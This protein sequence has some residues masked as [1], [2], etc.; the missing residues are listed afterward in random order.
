MPKHNSVVDRLM[1]SIRSG[2]SA[3]S[4]P[5]TVKKMLNMSMGDSLGVA[6]DWRHKFQEE[7]VQMIGSVL[8]DEEEKMEEALLEAK[9][10]CETFDVEKASQTL[11]LENAKASLK[12][13]KEALASKKK[14]FVAFDQNIEAKEQACNTTLHDIMLLKSELDG[15]ARAHGKLEE[16]L[17][18]V[19]KTGKDAEKV[20]NDV[21]N[22]LV[23][24]CQALNCEPSMVS[25]LPI[26]FEKV[27]EERCDFDHVVVE[28]VEGFLVMKEAAQRDIIARSQAEVSTTEAKLDV[29]REELQQSI[30]GKQLLESDVKSGEVDSKQAADNVRATTKALRELDLKRKSADAAMESAKVRLDQFREGALAAYKLLMNH[31]CPPAVQPSA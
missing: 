2:I 3:S 21:V 8:V 23:A 29:A 10:V 16:A 13:K 25:S 15:A 22:S 4:A 14:Q 9:Q 24:L 20:P 30:K 7:V 19:V 6:K 1:D 27:V 5:D 26:A 18:H 12:A 31:S 28:Q 11:A 17:A